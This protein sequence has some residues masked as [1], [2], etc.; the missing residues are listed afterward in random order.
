VD[1]RAL[2]KTAI[3]QTPAQTAPTEITPAPATSQ[4]GPAVTLPMP[5]ATATAAPASHS[6]LLKLILLV[7][8]AIVIVV[9][10]GLV[11]VGLWWLDRHQQN[12]NQKVVS[13]TRHAPAQQ[14]QNT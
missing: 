9:V 1:P 7:L 14:T 4:P 2:D 13:G 5:A 6:S 10:W 11:K 8:G 12:K 3:L